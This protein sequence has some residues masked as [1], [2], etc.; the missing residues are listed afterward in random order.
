[1]VSDDGKLD[2][3]IRNQSTGFDQRPSVVVLPA[4][5][6]SVIARSDNYGRIKVP[7]LIE[8][9]R[10]TM[11]YLDSSS[12]PH[13]LK[14]EQEKLIKAPDGEIIGWAANAGGQ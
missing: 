9:G 13:V 2:K 6:Y 5:R 10:T 11:V 7:V 8:E 1:L 12:Q 14:A 3:P 4:G